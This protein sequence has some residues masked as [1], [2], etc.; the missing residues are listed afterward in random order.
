MAG[1]TVLQPSAGSMFVR[2]RHRPCGLRQR[3][4]SSLTTQNLLTANG[5]LRGRWPAANM[6]DCADASGKRPPGRQCRAHRASVK[7][8]GVVIGTV[9]L[10]STTPADITLPTLPMKPGQ[11]VEVV[12]T[13]PADGRDLQL[14][15]AI[16]GK[17]VLLAGSNTLDAPLARAQPHRHPHRACSR[18]ARRRHRPHHAGAGR[19]HPR[20]QRQGQ[21]PPSNADY[22][23]AVPPMTAGRKLDIAYANDGA[24]DG[25][26][27]RPVHRLRHHPLHRLAARRCR[28]PL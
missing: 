10:R 22:S 12:Y 23:F 27:S 13:N 16:N 25:H 1:T 4:H 6:T 2:R 21:R 28:Q 20:G 15:Y 9:E 14:A 26:A 3:Q 19:R 5:A 11:R 24:V 7:V 18:H 8:D 17:T